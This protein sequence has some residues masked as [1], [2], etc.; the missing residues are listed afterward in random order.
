MIRFH[1]GY[2]SQ[3]GHDKAAF[4]NRKYRKLVRNDLRKAAYTAAKRAMTHN[5]NA[6]MELIVK[7]SSVKDAL[8][9]P[10]KALFR[11]GRGKLHKQPLNALWRKYN[12]N[13]PRNILKHGVWGTIPEWD[14]AGR[15]GVLV[16]YF[17]P[18]WP[19]HL[20]T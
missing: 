10:N 19:L 3:L 20:A 8:S 15:K 2:K 7:N 13:Y 16:V 11:I 14:A 18:I 17:V 6:L 9:D 12:G 1:T 4:D 5:T